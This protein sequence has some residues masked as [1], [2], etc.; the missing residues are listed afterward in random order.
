ML[1]ELP[2]LMEGEFQDQG[3]LV[4]DLE[5]WL[6]PRGSQS[7]HGFFYEEEKQDSIQIEDPAPEG[8]MISNIDPEG[9]TSIMVIIKWLEKV[10]GS[11][12]NIYSPLC[13]G[14]YKEEDDALVPWSETDRDAIMNCFTWY[15]ENN[16]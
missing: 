6:S 13:G 16:Y 15:K 9:E 4:Q 8:A 5:E 11:G 2:N 1:V 3:Q 14:L 10:E 12:D 7:V